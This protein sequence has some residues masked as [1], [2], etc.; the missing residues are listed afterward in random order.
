MNVWRP[1]NGRGK[2]KALEDKYYDC[3]VRWK[4]KMAEDPLFGAGGQAGKQTAQ[5]KS[6][7]RVLNFIQ[8]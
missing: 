5:L 6:M 1:W 3:D 4:E 8:K 2:S 7:L